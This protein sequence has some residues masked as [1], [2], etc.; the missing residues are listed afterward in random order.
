MEIYVEKAKIK[1]GVLHAEFTEPGRDGRN[2]VG[3]ECKTEVHQDMKD[4]FAL[5]N[6]HVA[7]LSEQ[8]KLGM[9]RDEYRDTWE[10]IDVRK[11]Y[12]MLDDSSE[13]ILNSIT[14]T[15]YTLGGSDEH[16]GVTLIGSR[17]L[18]NEKRLNLITPFQKFQDDFTPYDHSWE[19]EQVIKKCNEEVRLY[20]IEG[21][22]APIPEPPPEF[23]FP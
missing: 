15:G 16:E 2:K 22:C 13:D 19:L 20:L 1:D 9:E 6:I 7:L 23:P 17:K 3:K 10:Q 18:K 12:Y 11:R 4:A 8:I 14:C 5:L 21:K